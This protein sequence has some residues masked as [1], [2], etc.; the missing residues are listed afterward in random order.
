VDDSETMAMYMEP[1]GSAAKNTSGVSMEDVAEEVLNGFF[2]HYEPP[3][4]TEY[5]RHVAEQI[6]KN[7]NWVP[8]RRFRRHHGKSILRP[9][10]LYRDPGQNSKSV[11]WRDERKAPTIEVL[12]RKA[13]NCMSG[14]DVMN[15]ATMEDT[16]KA[17]PTPAGHIPPTPK[18]GVAANYQRQNRLDENDTRKSPRGSIPKKA[19]GPVLYDDEGYPYVD[20]DSDDDGIVDENMPPF[21]DVHPPSPI[22]K[23][24]SPQVMP[25]SP[26][27]M[28]PF[29]CGL[30]EA[31]WPS[32]AAPTPNQSDAYAMQSVTS[33]DDR[34]AP[35][36][37][38]L[39]YRRIRSPPVRNRYNHYDMEEDDEDEDADSYEARAPNRIGKA[40]SRT[41]M[42][43]YA[44][45]TGRRPQ[46]PS[47][48][49]TKYEAQYSELNR[50][51][52]PRRSPGR[53]SMFKRWRRPPTPS[54]RSEYDT[55]EEEEIA[56]IQ[57]S[58]SKLSK[59]QKEEDAYDSDG[60][61]DRLGRAMRPRRRSLSRD[62]G[63]QEPRR[64]RSPAR[65]KPDLIE[66]DRRG[67][68]RS[69]SRSREDSDY[70]QETEEEN[71][72][73]RRPSRSPI[74]RRSASADS[75]RDDDDYE[76]VDDSGSDYYDDDDD[77]D[78]QGRSRRRSREYDDRRSASFDYNRSR[79]P[80]DR[81]YDDYD[82][83]RRS[84]EYDSRQTPRDSEFL[85]NSSDFDGGAPSN[86]SRGEKESRG[87]GSR[88]STRALPV[89]VDQGPRGS[90]VEEDDYFPAETAVTKRG[91][92][93]ERAPRADRSRRVSDPTPASYRPKRRNDDEQDKDY[94]RRR[95][96]S[97]TSQASRRSGLA[98]DTSYDEEVKES[99][100]RPD[101]TPR[102]VERRDDV[103]YEKPKSRSQ[104][105]LLPP[106]PRRAEEE[107]RKSN[108]RV[109]D[110]EDDDSTAIRARRMLEKQLSPV[111]QAT[112]SEIREEVSSVGMES[113]TIRPQ[114]PN[115]FL[116][117]NPPNPFLRVPPILEET[118]T[119]DD[120]DPSTLSSP[121]P[122]ETPKAG[123]AGVKKTDS[124]SNK[125]SKK[126]TPQKQ[127]AS[128]PV[129]AASA[130]SVGSS[131]KSFLGTLRKKMGKVK[132]IVK[133][134]DEKRLPAPAF[135]KPEPRTNPSKE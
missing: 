70:A 102:K 49:N 57:A 96:H 130:G 64:G 15:C 6:R 66:E 19:K 69:P 104:Q 80:R 42:A 7:P 39:P 86:V 46:S 68:S 13:P 25:A 55:E 112:D 90:F 77:D 61:V 51:P 134:I 12:E 74:R 36:S 33:Q 18:M 20:E 45:T 98:L 120:S 119:T 28:N 40:P 132:S 114:Y 56:A 122:I 5:Q 82:E 131:K 71:M 123:Q 14:C 21:D 52:V 60:F 135:F 110:I 50:L 67:R 24:P 29:S 106:T 95:P 116:A 84:N 133:D 108:R 59:L 121:H 85:V 125:S 88:G 53:K 30:A 93:K 72:R 48:R 94:D 3:T 75:Y 17:P 22:E 54:R 26:H 81:D 8:N 16:S 4:S 89:T 127:T 27:L 47:R 10:R 111:S 38:S 32:M 44:Y 109:D 117:Q 126:K 113:S 91:P 107:T 100:G 76:S 103:V 105:P 115:P 129:T 92:T 128:Q 35:T 63:D 79:S 118:Q 43:P 1:G 34:R 58:T 23:L 83:G 124:R 65:G 101:P 62:R 99:M 11:T 41:P 9:S 37:Q 73:R 78:D 87:R 2:C 97:T 31:C